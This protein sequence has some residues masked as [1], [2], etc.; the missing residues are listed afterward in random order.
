MATQ[1]AARTV[2]PVF[3]RLRVLLLM[4][5][6]SIVGMAA[7]VGATT[8]TTFMVP[9]LV[10]T[11]VPRLETYTTTES[12]YTIIGYDR[13]VTTTTS[14]PI[15]L[16]QVYMHVNQY[17]SSSG[18]TTT[19]SCA[20]EWYW[21]GY[22]TPSEPSCGS[23]GNFTA[24][25]VYYTYAGHFNL[26]QQVIAGYTTSTSTSIVR[27]PDPPGT[28]V[29]GWVTTTVTRTRTVYDEVVTL[30]YIATNVCINPT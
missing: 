16:T 15:Y 28:A 9:T 27:Y 21:L 8:C 20:G 24:G 23:H 22:W 10:T 29:Y 19:T 17:S 18:L 13:E 7:P 6:A 3:R 30:E 1:I 4:A 2:G 26:T 14:T 5:L 12:V 11:W 25:G